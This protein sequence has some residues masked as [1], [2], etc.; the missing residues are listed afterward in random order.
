MLNRVKPAEH[1]GQ[2]TAMNKSTPLP[3]LIVSLFTLSSCIWSGGND[4]VRY[5]HEKIADLNERAL[6]TA[7]K[8]NMTVATQ[9]L[10]EALRLSSTL[11]YNDGQSVSLLN[12][13]RLARNS[14]Y[15]RL[16]AD[17]ADRAL[18][19]SAGTETYPDALQEKAI[20]ELL[21][22]DLTKAASWA[23]QSLKNEPGPLKGRRLNLMARISFKAGRM[24]ECAAFLDQALRANS[25]EMMAEERANT[26]RLMGIVN[27]SLKNL[28]KAEEQLHAALGI[29]KDL[30][31]PEK[32]AD[33]L[34]AIAAFYAIKGDAKKRDDYTERAE[35]VR[36][37]IA[38]GKIKGQTPTLKST[39]KL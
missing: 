12:M 13:A 10:D 35:N 23:A 8:G 21:A 25:P 19:V 38:R 24:G 34:E 30:E 3:F 32:I 36:I 6:A 1:S 17:Y 18:K 22:G 20:Q 27:G 4:T 26:L 31:I 11:D 9:L 33:D 37:N 15:S 5:Q 14:G 7:E 39:D 28:E 2:V 29:D 16:A